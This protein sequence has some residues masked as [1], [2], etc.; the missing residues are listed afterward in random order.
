MYPLAHFYGKTR[1][2]K[3]KVSDLF[4]TRLSRETFDGSG[5]HLLLQLTAVDKSRKDLTDF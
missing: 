4:V 5:S 1:K 2:E 3:I